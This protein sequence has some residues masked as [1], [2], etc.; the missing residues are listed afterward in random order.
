MDEAT[1]PSTKEQMSGRYIL[2]IGN[3]FEEVVEVWSA[4]SLGCDLP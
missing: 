1:D 4:A 3:F 2:D